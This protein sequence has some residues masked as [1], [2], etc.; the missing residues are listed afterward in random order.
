M[1]SKLNGFQGSSNIISIIGPTALTSKLK[2]WECWVELELL[3]QVEYNNHNNV[4]ISET[5]QDN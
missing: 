4:F 1:L 2:I 3:A 5:E